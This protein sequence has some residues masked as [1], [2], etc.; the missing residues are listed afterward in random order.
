MEGIVQKLNCWDEPHIT[1]IQFADLHNTMQNQLK[2]KH[3]SLMW[4]LETE[5]LLNIK[6]K[7]VL[8]NERTGS[9][10][11]LLGTFIEIS[12]FISQEDWI[13]DI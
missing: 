4:Q 5:S 1:S 9:L 7:H 2:L 12:Y 8:V 3:D 10:E 11:Q 13:K 6:F